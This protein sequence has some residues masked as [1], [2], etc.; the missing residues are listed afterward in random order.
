[1]SE[2]AFIHESLKNNSIKETK[3]N[4]NDLLRLCDKTVISNDNSK[5]LVKLPTDMHLPYQKS[6]NIL[7]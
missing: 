7:R 4:N 3:L 6:I 5:S 2:R 1:M